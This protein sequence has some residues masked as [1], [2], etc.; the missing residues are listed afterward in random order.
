[1]ACASRCTRGSNLI[2]AREVLEQGRGPGG[3]RAACCRTGLLQGDGRPEVDERQK[4]TIPMLANAGV[5]HSPEQRGATYTVVEIVNNRSD[6]VFGN[7][8]WKRR[9]IH[10]VSINAF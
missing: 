10:D 8:G 3:R 9:R 2:K 6:Q 5:E 1:M 7:A 4:V